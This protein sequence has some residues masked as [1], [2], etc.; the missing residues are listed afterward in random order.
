M[1]RVKRLPYANP[2]NGNRRLVAY[3]RN[4]PNAPYYVLTQEYFDDEYRLTHH[5]YVNQQQTS[6]QC[7]VK[8]L[9]SP[10]APTNDEHAT[11]I[12]ADWLYTHS[13]QKYKL[14]EPQPA[15]LA[16]PDSHL[17]DSFDECVRDPKLRYLTTSSQ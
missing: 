2:L 6:K 10:P 7:P 3:W 16:D 12:A 5:F 4:S 17:P 14:T 13:C 11:K 8:A 15:M 1:S 9:K